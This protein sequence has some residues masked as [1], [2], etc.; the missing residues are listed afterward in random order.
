MHICNEI[1]GSCS[2]SSWITLV[3][4]KQLTHQK[5]HPFTFQH[6]TSSHILTNSVI[7]KKSKAR[8]ALELYTNSVIWKKSKAREA[9]ELYKLEGRCP[10]K[11][12]RCRWTNSSKSNKS[13]E[14]GDEIWF[15]EEWDVIRFKN[16]EFEQVWCIICLLAYI[17]V[18]CDLIILI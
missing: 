13:F 2:P 11:M 1:W 15:R 7:W 4:A 3:I 16:D 12:Q 9:L 10:A 5:T 14:F 17:Q 6:L 18:W 8:E